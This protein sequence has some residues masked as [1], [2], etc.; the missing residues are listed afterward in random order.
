VFL[1]TK[2][3]DCVDK[4]YIII[5]MHQRM[6]A[7]GAVLSD[8]PETADVIVEVGSGG[9]GTDG[10]EL[11]VGVPEIPLPPPS[12]VAIPRMNI[13]TRTRL[14]GTAKVVVVAYDAKTRMP[15]INAGWSL[16]RSDQNTWNFLGAG[17]IQTGL[18][19]DQ[20]AATGETD[21]SVVGVTR[22]ARRTFSPA[23]PA[24]ETPAAVMPAGGTGAARP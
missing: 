18:V 7:S 20:I 13:F 2:Y 11:F 4:N 24:K 16:A 19:P 9:V 14:N 3:L 5:A 15:V 8:K 21:L 17:P 1:E 22:A 12:P 6:L 10:Q 23:E